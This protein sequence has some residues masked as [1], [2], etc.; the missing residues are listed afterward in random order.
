MK[1]GKRPC[2]RLPVDPT[3][4][5]AAP[6]RPPAGLKPCYTHGC[7]ASPDLSYSCFSFGATSS[8]KSWIRQWTLIVD[9]ALCCSHGGYLGIRHNEVRDLLGQLLDETCPNVSLE[10][11]LQP[12]SGEQLPSS[13]NTTEGARVDIQ[14]GKT[15]RVC[16]FDVRVFHTHARSYRTRHRTIQQTFRPHEQEKRRAYETRIWQVDGG[17]FTP[18]CNFWLPPLE[19]PILQRLSS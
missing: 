10:P 4:G 9:H 17:S 8:L 3:R 12:L 14:A 18:V 15:A 5:L 16:L 1:Y 6:P 7:L 11:T 19:S 2:M 13:S